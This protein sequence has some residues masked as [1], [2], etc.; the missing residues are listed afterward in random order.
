MKK[1]SSTK[2]RALVTGA[3]R[4]IGRA[5]AEALARDGWDVIGTCRNPKKLASADRVEGVTYVPL[6]LSREASIETLLKSVKDVDLLVNNAGESPIGPA[7]EI[8]VKDVRGYFQV[9]FFGAVRLTQGVL[10]GMRK[11]KGGAIVFIGSVRSEVPTPFAST[12]SSTKAA[13]K[14]FGECLRLELLGTGV[15]VAVLAPWYVRTGFPQ[16]LTVAKKSPYAEALTN[17]KKIRDK[18]I[19]NSQDPSVVAKKVL[20]IARGK[21]PSPFSVIGKPLLTCFIH[22]APRGLVA[23]TSARTTGMKPGTVV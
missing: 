23:R 4:G 10:P 1:A 11:R 17:V 13:I 6:D 14:S 2:G 20:A 3:S 18:M 9:N 12:Y 7:E 16:K 8:P 15:R 5:V 21:N 19:A 22:H